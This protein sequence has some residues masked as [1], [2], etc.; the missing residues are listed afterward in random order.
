MY[1]T[2]YAWEGARSLKRATWL[3][4]WGQRC[5]ASLRPQWLSPSVRK[6]PCGRS[7]EALRVPMPASSLHVR[8]GYTTGASARKPASWR[9]RQALLSVWFLET[10]ACRQDIPACLVRALWPWE[11][12]ETCVLP[13]LGSARPGLGWAERSRVRGLECKAPGAR[14]RPRSGCRGGP[15]PF[16]PSTAR[17]CTSPPIRAAAC[18]PGREAARGVCVFSACGAKG[19]SNTSALGRSSDALAFPVFKT[20]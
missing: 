1:R 8:N 18:L 4:P 3:R 9:A 2:D 16:T 5:W 17:Q 15:A 20:R 14:P 11:A 6:G 7:D 12:P 13:S 19:L 10:Q